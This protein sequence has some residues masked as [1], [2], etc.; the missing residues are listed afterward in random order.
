MSTHFDEEHTQKRV[1]ALHFC[2]GILGVLEPAFLL[3][4]A[5]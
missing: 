5:L 3:H 1:C 2:Y 4:F